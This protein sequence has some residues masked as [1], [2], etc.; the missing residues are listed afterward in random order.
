MVSTRPTNTS[1]ARKRH[2]EAPKKHYLKSRVDLVNAAD[3]GKSP[4]RKIVARK[5]RASTKNPLPKVK[6]VTK[7]KPVMKNK[8]VT[9]KTAP[10]KTPATKKSVAAKEPST[11][12][13]APKAKRATEQPA[14]KTKKKT[15]SSTK[16]LAKVSRATGNEVVDVDALDCPTHPN[17]VVDS[18]PPNPVHQFATAGAFV[19]AISAGTA[20]CLLSPN[21]DRFIVG[22]L[23]QA[24]RGMTFTQVLSPGSEWISSFFE[25]DEDEDVPEMAVAE[26]PV[27]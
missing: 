17:Q 4:A 2:G 8:D 25:E 10:K 18:P 13:P 11:K 23:T 6:P 27:L 7:N 21:L 12:K 22:F 20:A 5:T 24:L 3:P 14:A 9:K 19:V 15:V 26:M 16:K 1:S